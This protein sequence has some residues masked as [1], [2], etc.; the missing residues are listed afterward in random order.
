MKFW[1]RIFIT[2]GLAEQKEDFEEDYQEQLHSSSFKEKVVSFPGSKEMKVMLLKPVQFD[3]AEKIAGHLKKNKPVLLNVENMSTEEA[4]RTIDF[5]S[6]AAYALGG[7]SQKI[8]NQIFVFTPAHV[9][10][11]NEE[12]NNELNERR[13]LLDGIEK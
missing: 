3:E 7:Q 4:K 9:S 1:E 10:L 12:I 2:L 11:S 13:I 6:G 5:L 8:G